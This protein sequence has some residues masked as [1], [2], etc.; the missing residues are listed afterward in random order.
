MRKLNES[1]PLYKR[2][3]SALIEEDD[4]EE[5]VQFNG[6]KNLSLHY[7]SDDSHCG[8]CT[9]IDTEFRERDRMEFEVES[10]GDFQ[11]P[12]SG[13]FDRFSSER[14]VVSN[15]FRNGGM[16]I[17]VHSNEQWI[18]DDDLSHSDAALGNETYSNSL[19]QL[20][21]REVNIPNFPVSDTQY[22]LMSL[23]ERLLLELQS[24]GVF[25]EAMPDLAEETMSTDVME[26][27]E[28]IYQ[29]IL[30]KKKKL[31]KL[32]ITIQKGKDVEKRK[33]EHL[34]MDQLVE[35]A[36]KKRM[37]CR[38]SKAAK[39]NKVTR[40]VALGFIRRTVARC[41]KFEETG[42]SC[43]SDPALQ[44]ILFSSPS[45]DAKSSENG[46]SGTASNTLNEPS[47]HQ[48]EAKG[49]GAVSST[50]RREA[51]IDDVIGCASSK[52]TTSK[53]SAVLSGGG[54][55]GKRSEREDGFRNKNKP[56]PK[57]NNNNNN[58]N[59][60]RSTTT[61]THPTGPASRGASNRGVTSGD[62]AVDDEAPIDFS[63]LAFRDLDEI[64]EQADL[65]NWFEGLQDIDTAGLDEVPMDDLSFMFG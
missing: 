58:G 21:A 28:G 14:S 30:N 11:T 51:L 63:K 17:S 36:H 16:S 65:G 40:Q 52:V 6:G 50:K 54:A 34:A 10:S 27:K 57:E 38:G 37:A 35:T 46:G 60:S 19:G 56:K 42:F 55:Q 64:D 49:S 44:D 20:Q 29:E 18:G 8:S 1:T 61:S 47:N 31:E 25:P 45:N 26:L 12:K 39:V 48:A 23:D 3:L 53:G 5:V 4:G 32:I 59:Q 24:I 62:G 22:Q 9:Y 15:P 41:R 7:A 13:L 33:I 43:F 2:V